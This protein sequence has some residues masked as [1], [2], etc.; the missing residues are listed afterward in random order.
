MNNIVQFESKRLDDRTAPVDREKLN[1]S[2]AA[3]NSVKLEAQKTTREFVEVT[4][5]LKEAVE[6]LGETCRLYQNNLSQ[7][8]V[9]SLNQKSRRLAQI[10]DQW[11]TKD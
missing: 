7:L 8:N 5:T 11:A 6:V 4:Q 3:L 9:K 10:M 1:A 2:I